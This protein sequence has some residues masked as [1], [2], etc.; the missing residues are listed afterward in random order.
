MKLH[1]CSFKL[2][3]S[4]KIDF[5]PF[6][7][8]QKTDFGHSKIDTVFQVH[9]AAAQWGRKLKKSPGQKKLM[10]SNKSISRNPHDQIPF[11]RFQ[12]W[13]KINF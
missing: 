11:L 7:K 13:P 8:L 12:K 3:P 1:F 10:N 6:L 9:C 5:W 4:S 2:F